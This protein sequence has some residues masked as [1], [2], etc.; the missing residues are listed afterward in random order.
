MNE[1]GEKVC[2][3]LIYLYS[4]FVVCDALYQFAV[5][6]VLLRV[7]FRTSLC[8]CACARAAERMTWKSD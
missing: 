7:R 5:L 1:P 6:M 8:V 4:I 3:D 2:Q